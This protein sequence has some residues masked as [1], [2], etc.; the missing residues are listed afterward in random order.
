MP[1]NSSL[2]QVFLQKSATAIGRNRRDKRDAEHANLPS[3][4]ASADESY[5][6]LLLL[7]RLSKGNRRTCR[8]VGVSELLASRLAAGAGRDALPTRSRAI[9]RQHIRWSFPV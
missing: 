8:R 4:A 2:R 1:I 3:G 9:R 6:T 5:E 7:C